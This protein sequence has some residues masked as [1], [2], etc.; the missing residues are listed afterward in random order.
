MPNQPI[1]LRPHDICVA[2]QL[3]LSGKTSFRSLASAVGLSL[4]E[5][6]NAAQRLGVARLISSDLSSTNN[7]GLF[8]F[9]AFGVPYC[10]PGQLGPGTRGVPTA[11]SGPALSNLVQQS[12]PIVWPSRLGEV[13]GAS[14]APL[15]KGAPAMKN[16]NPDLYRLLTVVDALRI[17]RARERGIAEQA[18]R[19][20][21]LDVR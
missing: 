9:L 13:R 20:A 5:T 18:L 3:S 21:L 2:L 10:F 12:D 19:E 14:L 15:C 1:A 16:A 6:H 17:G 8:D 4:G 7:P 11:H